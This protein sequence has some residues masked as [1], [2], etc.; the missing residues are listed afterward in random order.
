MGGVEHEPAGNSTAVKKWVDEEILEVGASLSVG[1]NS[2]EPQHASVITDRDPSP[3]FGDSVTRED[4]ELRTGQQ[5]RGVAFVGQGSRPVDPLQL[6]QVGCYRCP[7]AHLRGARHRLNLQ[8]APRSSGP[9]GDAGCDAFSL[10]P[11]RSTAA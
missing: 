9:V 10:R 4:K 1:R 11:V 2:G 8:R 3:L 5:Q 7:D 6:G